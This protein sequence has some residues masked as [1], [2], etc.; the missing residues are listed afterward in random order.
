M[1]KVWRFA[2]KHLWTAYH[3][4]Y[5]YSTHIPHS[6]YLNLQIGVPHMFLIKLL[7]QQE[8]EHNPIIYQSKAMN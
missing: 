4:G 6:L 5:N 3:N 1:F 8:V 7:N 2:V